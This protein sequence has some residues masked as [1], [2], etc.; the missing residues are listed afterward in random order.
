MAGYKS[1]GKFLR[2]GASITLDDCFIIHG[3]RLAAAKMAIFFLCREGK[4]LYIRI[5]KSRLMRFASANPREYCFYYK[6]P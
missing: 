4:R 5:K 3:L 2:T 6:K 1:L